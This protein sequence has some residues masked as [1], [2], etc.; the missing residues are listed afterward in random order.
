MHSDMGDQYPNCEVI[1]TDLS[2]IQPSWFPPN[3]K[4]EIDDC[5]QEWTFAP[6]SF[7][8]V[9]CGY[10]MGGVS[11]WPRLFRQAYTALRPGGW[12]ESFEC[13]ADYRSDDGTIPRDSAMMTWSDLFREGGERLGRPFTIVTE[14]T[15]KKSMEAAGFVDITVKNI[16]LRGGLPSHPIGP[17]STREDIS[18]E[19]G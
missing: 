14:E 9:H 3:V 1:G 17:D 7:D 11:D 15:Q 8:F 13:E 10:M 5:E 4:F 6:D 19:S 18:L 2:P 16:K 12:L